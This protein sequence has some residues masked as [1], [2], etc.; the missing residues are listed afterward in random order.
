MESKGSREEKES[1]NHECRVEKETYDDKLK[2]EIS[3]PMQIITANK[4]SRKNRA[5]APSSPSD[6]LMSPCSRKLRRKK[7][8]AGNSSSFDFWTPPTST[9]IILGSSSK[10]RALILREMGW[11]FS[12]MPPDINER[13]IQDKYSDEI[14]QVPVTIAKAKA[15]AIQ[16]LLNAENFVEEFEGDIV[17]L[18]SDQVVVFRDEIRGKP[19]DLSQAR[20]F[21]LSYNKGASCQTVTAVVATHL[22]SGRQESDVDVCTIHWSG[23]PEGVVERLIA[24]D[25]VMYSCGGF[26][27]EDNDFL[28]YVDHID[29]SIDS[30]RGLPKKTTR[31]LV[32][33]VLGLYYQAI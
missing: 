22:P 9:K 6:Q 16:M 20:D 28:E 2:E 11:S 18:T 5:F 33:S 29:G 21:L 14:M 10:S 7:T 3:K 8:D 31:K 30:I 19:E 24:K 1:L 15:S 27:I 32:S 23:I 26:L 17:I 12:T 4:L 13:E 25:D